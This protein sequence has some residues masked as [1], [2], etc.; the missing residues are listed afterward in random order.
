MAIIYDEKQSLFTLYTKESMYQMKV[1]QYGILLHTYYGKKTEHFDYSYLLCCQD[2]GMAGSPYEAGMDRTYSI[3]MIPQ[4]YSC[5]GTGDFRSSALNIQDGLGCE[6]ASL[7]YESHAILD[8]KYAIPGLPAL[9]AMEENQAQTLIVTMKDAVTG[10]YVH[11]YYGVMED[12]DVITRAVRI[13][14]KGEKTVHLKRAMSLCLDQM[15]GDYDFI[16]FHGRHVMERQFSRD[17]VRHGIQ[18]VGGV[19]GA[20]SLQYNPFVIL[21]DKKAGETSGECYGFS[22]LYSGNFLAQAELDQANQTRVLLGI[23]PESFDFTLT[24]GEDFWTPEAAMVY[25][26]GGFEKMSRIFH[27]AYRNNLCRGKFKKARRPVLINNWEGT[28]FDLPVTSWFA[29]LQKRQRWA[30]SSLSWMMAGSENA[31]TITAVLGIG[32]SMRKSW[33]AL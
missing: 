19:R 23:H 33:A 12:L 13:E 10:V 4:E 28:Y 29:W 30:W 24:S 3:E 7:R 1:D 31:M 32:M 26:D 22:F 9:Y 27:K 25:S 6:V 2:R 20:S 16:T 5:F 15:Y 21:A 18:S 8:E 17:A 14:N 11:L